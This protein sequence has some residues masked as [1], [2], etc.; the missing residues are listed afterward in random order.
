[1]TSAWKIL[2]R[3]THFKCELSGFVGIV[4]LQRFYKMLH[5]VLEK[6]KIKKSIA[7]L[8]YINTATSTIM[9]LCLKVWQGV[10]YEPHTIY[11][12]G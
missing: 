1:M 12:L 10:S 4:Y 9:H 11:F 5:F 7:R 8:N 6:W 3:W 2:A